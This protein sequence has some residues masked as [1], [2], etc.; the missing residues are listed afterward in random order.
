MDGDGD[1]DL[2]GSNFILE[3]VNTDQFATKQ[4]GIPLYEGA[5][6]GDFNGDGNPDIFALTIQGG[7]S[8]HLYYSQGPN[9]FYKENSPQGLPGS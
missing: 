6:L 7:P 9:F 4:T 2:V 1:L 5:A 8:T 3:N